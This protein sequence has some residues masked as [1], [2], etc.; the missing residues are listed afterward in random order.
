[1]YALLSSRVYFFVWLCWGSVIFCS[2]FAVF[3]FCFSGEGQ[4]FVGLVG[5]LFCSAFAF[6]EENVVEL[7]ALTFLFRVGLF[8][9]FFVGV[10][11]SRR[12]VGV[13]HFFMGFCGCGGDKDT[14]C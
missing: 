4:C 7:V 10:G 3:C 6:F 2:A 14:F 9:Q 1:M 11:L 5:I 12:P 13:S 8:A